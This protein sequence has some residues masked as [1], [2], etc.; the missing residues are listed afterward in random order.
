MPLFTEIA[1]IVVIAV[2]AGFIAHLL[3]QPV[4]VG[5]LAAGFLIGL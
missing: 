5:F 2:L 3:R 1:I 4:I